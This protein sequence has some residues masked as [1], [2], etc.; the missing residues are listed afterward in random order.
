MSDPLATYLSDHMGGAQVALQLLTAMR[1]RNDDPSLREFAAGLLPSIEE[2]HSTLQSIAA[3]IGV[4]DGA[5]AKQAG[6][7]LLEKASRVKL[8]HAGS[9]RFEMFESFELLALGVHGKIG[10]WKAL[11]AAA[12]RDARLRDWDFERL[13]ARA[14]NQ[15]Q[16]VENR[17]LHL[18]REVL[19][20]AG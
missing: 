17:R 10:L 8:G 2:D 14:T 11:Q 15:F 19:P 1:D 18:A 20:S 4:H 13:A 7:W 3:G 9:S 12:E 5:P 6:G 16:A